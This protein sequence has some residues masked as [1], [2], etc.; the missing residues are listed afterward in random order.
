VY[1]EI[2]DKPEL[3]MKSNCLS[4]RWVHGLILFVIVTALAACSSTSKRAVYEGSKETRSLEVP[5]DLVPPD[6]SQAFGIPTAVSARASSQAGVTERLLP[7]PKGAR[8]V[9]EGDIRWLEIDDSPERVWSQLHAFFRQQ[10]FEIKYEDAAMGIMET[11]WRENRAN[12]PSNWLSR[13]LRKLYSSGLLDKYRVRL[14]RTDDPNKTRVYIT[15]RGLEEV[16]INEDSNVDIVETSWQPRPSDPELEAE[17]MR[18]F[19]VFRGLDEEQAKQI[20]RGQT[21]GPRAELVDVDGIQGI[22]VNQ[23][24]ARSWR[25]VGLALDRLGLEVE[26]RDRSRGQYYI[27]LSEDFLQQHHKEGSVFA[28][29]FGKD[30]KPV[31]T[32]DQYILKV[33]DRG[34]TTRISLYDRDGKAVSG[35]LVTVLINELYKQLR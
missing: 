8:L 20:A 29:L 21:V 23:N 6:S 2:F 1:S 17:M 7:R 18:R 19:L 16:A 3:Y 35:E 24:F 5:P 4:P 28:R 12:L 30:E 31:V 33:E 22:R 34:A 11:D 9:Q 32:E 10:G 13:M 26:D 25:R 14:E 27:R 15:H